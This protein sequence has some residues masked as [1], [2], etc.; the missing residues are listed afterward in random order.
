MLNRKEVAAM[1]ADVEDA[2]ES[3]EQ[4]HFFVINTI[5]LFYT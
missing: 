4:V 2:L 1:I 5:K 3:L